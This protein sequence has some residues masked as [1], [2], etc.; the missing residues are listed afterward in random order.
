MK[1]RVC[2]PVVCA[3]YKKW[4]LSGIDI[5]MGTV[6]PADHRRQIPRTGPGSAPSPPA[7]PGPATRGRHGRPG[8]KFTRRQPFGSQHGALHPGP[9]GLHPSRPGA[10]PGVLLRPPPCCRLSW[11]L[12]QQPCIHP[13]MI[14]NTYTP[15]NCWKEYHAGY[16]SQTEKRPVC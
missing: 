14:L 12:S 4:L 13:E 6:L 5:I 2:C 10:G 15:H 8:M 1:Q 11:L 3:G 16:Y 7:R 9:E